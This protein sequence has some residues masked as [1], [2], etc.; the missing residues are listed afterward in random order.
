MI[1]AIWDRVTRDNVLRAFSASILIGAACFAFAADGGTNI[2]VSGWVIDSACAYTKGLDK[3]IGVARARACGGR[4]IHHHPQLWV[5][6]PYVS[7]KTLKKERF[8][9]TQIY[10]SL[11]KVQPYFLSLSVLPP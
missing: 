1:K 10:L 8:E 7:L 3:P 2:T 11:S 5:P 9:C 6:H 4:P